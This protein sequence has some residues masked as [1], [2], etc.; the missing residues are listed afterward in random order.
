MI[1]CV[2]KKEKPRRAPQAGGGPVGRAVS[3]YFGGHSLC[4]GAS[5]DGGG[6][7]PEEAAPGSALPAYD[8]DLVE[9]GMARAARRSHR[10]AG[11]WGDEGL[12][13]ADQAR[14]AGEGEPMVDPIQASASDASGPAGGAA[15]PHH[16]PHPVAAGKERQRTPDLMVP[17]KKKRGFGGAATRTRVRVTEADLESN[18]EAANALATNPVGSESGPT[19]GAGELRCSGAGLVDVGR[20]NAALTAVPDDTAVRRDRTARSF[21]AL[22]K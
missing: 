6:Q 18:G 22:D 16:A 15:G 8:Q 12:A 13:R 1:V 19:G 3:P 10:D 20:A 11:H 9:K 7:G 17:Y 4:L 14:S 21:G 2:A 5:S